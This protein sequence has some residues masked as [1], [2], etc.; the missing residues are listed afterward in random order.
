M[1]VVFRVEAGNG[2]GGGHLMRCL[3]LAHRLRDL[4]AECLFVTFETPSDFI[5][6]I[7]EQGY[8]TDFAM[9]VPPRRRTVAH[10]RGASVALNAVVDATRFQKSVRRVFK[11]AVDWVIVDH[12]LLGKSWEILTKCISRKIFVIDDLIDR[13]HQC[14]VFLNQNLGADRS[15]YDSLLQ[16]STRFL[17]GPRYAL[18]RPEFSEWR[19]KSLHRRDDGM[20]GRILMN[21]GADDN[22]DLMLEALALMQDVRFPTGYSLTVVTGKSCSSLSQIRRACAALPISIEIIEWIPDYA[23]LLSGVDFVVGAAGSS[24][25]E[26]CVLGVPAM[27]FVIAENQIKAAYAMESQGIIEAFPVSSDGKKLWLSRF[28]A[29]LSDPGIVAAMSVRAREVCDGRGVDLICEEVFSDG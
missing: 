17:L 10:A 13:A 29:W 11:G 9:A 19:S 5:A 12:Y 14:D 28:R 20:S 1:K 6:V 18:I 21:F 4:G 16:P 25:W 22:G 23:A 27:V 3:V 26:R 2:K 15:H 7:R 8:L 24:S